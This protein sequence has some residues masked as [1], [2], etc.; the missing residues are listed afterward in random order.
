M[1][2]V[3][4]GPN[5]SEQFDD[6]KLLHAPPTHEKALEIRR[7]CARTVG[8]AMLDAVKSCYFATKDKEWIRNDVEDK[9]HLFTKPC[10]HKYPVG[11]ALDVIVLRGLPS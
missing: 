8:E 2:A 3:T 4:R 7:E 10:V 1:L 6:T 9:V 5:N 11:S